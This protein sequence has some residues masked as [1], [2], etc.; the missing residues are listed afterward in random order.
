MLKDKIRSEKYVVYRASSRPQGDVERKNVT[1]LCEN[2]HY[3]C[4]AGGRAEEGK[5]K[6]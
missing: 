1:V 4:L 3:H 5:G 6:L 2:S